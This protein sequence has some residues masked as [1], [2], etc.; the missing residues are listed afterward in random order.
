MAISNSAFSSSTATTTIYIRSS[1][2]LFH[3]PHKTMTRRCVNW[4][5]FFACVALVR[6]KENAVCCCC[7]CCG[8][9]R[10]ADAFGIESRFVCRANALAQHPS[11]RSSNAPPVRT[12]HI[13]QMAN[14][15]LWA[16]NSACP[17]RSL[18]ATNNI[19]FIRT[20]NIYYQSCFCLRIYGKYIVILCMRHREWMLIV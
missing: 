6:E 17:Y 10:G 18:A 2:S 14:G 20:A 4:L 15:P 1:S 19:L 7:C 11:Q 13:M 3:Q 9:G 5:V 16:Y 8:R 12:G